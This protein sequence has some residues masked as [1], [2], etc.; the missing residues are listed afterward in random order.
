MSTQPTSF[1][2]EEEYFVIDGTAERRSEYFNGEMFAMAGAEP[3]H[4]LIAVNISGELRQRLKGSTC[5]ALASDQ[6]VKTPTGLLTYPAVAIAC[7]RG[8]FL[9]TTPKTLLNPTVIFEVLSP[10]T[11][12]YDRGGKARHYRSVP[13]LRDYL[14]VA[15]DRVAVE[16]FSRQDEHHWTFVEYTDLTQEIALPSIGCTLPLSEIYYGYPFDLS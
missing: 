9:Y 16:H 5:R 6:R 11:E 8:E 4:V 14:L 1:L 2:S 7:G 15:T 12:T 10:S 3:P 13:T